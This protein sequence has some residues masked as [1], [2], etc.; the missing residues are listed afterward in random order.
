M[1]DNKAIKISDQEEYDDE[2]DEDFEK[3]MTKLSTSELQKT[4]KS[5]ESPAGLEDS[6][7]SALAN[8]PQLSKADIAKLRKKMAGMS[9]AQI[10]S[11][12][13]KMMGINDFGL[14]ADTNN[15]SAVT[16]DHKD[17]LSTRLKKQLAEKRRMRTSTKK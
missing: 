4:V 1:A 6:N 11:M 9:K 12:L 8:G 17:D 16:E 2:L 5:F 14:G 10:A 7:S 13:T 3:D 15:L